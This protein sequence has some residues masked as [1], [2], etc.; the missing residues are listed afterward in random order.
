MDAVRG[1]QHKVLAEQFTKL[2]HDDGSPDIALRHANL[3]NLVSCLTPWELLY[4]T[5]LTRKSP[6]KLAEMQ[7]LPEEVVA[8]IS[9]HLR[10]G[11]AIKCTQVSKPWRQKWTCHTVVNDIAHVCFPGLTAAFPDTPAWDLLRPIA[12]K[13]TARN[14]GKITSWLSI[15]TAD[16]PLLECTALKYDDLSLEFAKSNPTATPSRFFRKDNWDSRSWRGFAYSH[17][18]VAWQWD[19][20]R[21][22]VDDIRAMTRKL[23]SPPDLVVRGDKDFIVYAMTENLLILAN[24]ITMRALIVYDLNKGEHRRVTLPNRMLDL[25]A[26]KDTFAIN[27]SIDYCTYRQDDSATPPHVWNWS[28]GLVKLDV[29]GSPAT[30]EP[31]RYSYA[32]DEHNDEGA[33]CNNGNTAI[34]KSGLPGGKTKIVKAPS[35]PLIT[36]NFNT[37]TESFVVEKR[38]LSGMR[39]PIWEHAAGE[40][41]QAGGISWNDSVYY[42]Q[43]KDC[44]LR[45]E[46]EPRWRH[47]FEGKGPR[48][49]C[50]ANKT[51]TFVLE[52]KNLWFKEP[53]RGA[54][55]ERFRS[56][57][58]DDD[59]V[60]GLSRRSY[61]VYNFGDPSLKGGPWSEPHKVQRYTMKDLD[62]PKRGCPGPDESRLC[63]VCSDITLSSLWGHHADNESPD[64]SS[65]EDEESSEG[66]LSEPEHWAGDSN[67]AD[68]GWETSEYGDGYG[69]SY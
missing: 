49:I 67:E 57:A 43:N 34:F 38:V 48:S 5:Q 45:A 16:V 64:V 51:S 52:T 47:R 59:F 35:L 68:E 29:P 15:R 8:M 6:A 7:N 13:A 39:R 32:W 11:D 1:D 46:F 18:K 4:L 58:V 23:V 36:I 17:G 53:G 14:Q 55:R 63:P 37:T 31:R 66:V 41:A 33:D 61:V 62:C 40:P 60:V 50:I 21:F 28:T 42:I 10:L 54:R 22:F 69:Y 24:Q 26:H 2:T 44:R 9:R 30:E 56:I 19:S 27:F 12:Q 3:D 65:D 25:Q 20:Y